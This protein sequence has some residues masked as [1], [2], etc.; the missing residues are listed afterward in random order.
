MQHKANLE[1]EMLRKLLGLGMILNTDAFRKGR[2][3]AHENRPETD[4][5]YIPGELYRSDWRLGWRVARKA[6]SDK[7]N[8]A[9]A[10]RVDAKSP[11]HMAW[12]AAS[13]GLCA[14]LNSFLPGRP[15]HDQWRLGWARG[16]VA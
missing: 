7:E 3:A 8:R 14:S 12:A 10:L 4:N 13:Q 15:A 6:A 5:R 1:D 2:D 16:E 11:F 9:I